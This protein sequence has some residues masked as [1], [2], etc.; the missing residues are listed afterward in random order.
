MLQGGISQNGRLITQ[1]FLV[2]VEVAE[3]VSVD[4]LLDK[5]AD[6]LRFMEGTGNIEVEHL[7]E[8]DVIEGMDVVVNDSNPNNENPEEDDFPPMKES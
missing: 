2:A 3:G 1:G 8:L 7:G 4:R 6:S 5:I